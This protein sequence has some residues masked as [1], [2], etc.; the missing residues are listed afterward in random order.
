[1]GIK[2][3]RATSTIEHSEIPTQPTIT[4]NVARIRAALEEYPTLSI[5]PNSITVGDRRHP[6][7]DA[8]LI[9]GGIKPC[10]D[11]KWLVGWRVKAAFKGFQFVVE[12]KNSERFGHR[13]AHPKR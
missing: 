8:G 10:F 12:S 6:N 1:L 2:R 3:A 13:R 9:G 5:G 4:R 11:G 7:G